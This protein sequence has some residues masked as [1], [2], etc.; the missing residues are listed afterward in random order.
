MNALLC[1]NR[2]DAGIY[3]HTSGDEEERIHI[4]EILKGFIS[5]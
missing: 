1:T 2:K 3:I 4:T 5:A